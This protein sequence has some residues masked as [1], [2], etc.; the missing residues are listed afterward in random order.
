M[1]APQ[2]PNERWSLDFVA[3]Q[4]I[5]GRRMRILVVVDD[6]SRAGGL[7]L[8]PTLDLGLAG[9]PRTQSPD[10]P[11]IALITLPQ[12]SQCPRDYIFDDRINELS[13]P[14]ANGIGTSQWA[15]KTEI[16]CGL[17]LIKG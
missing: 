15:Q 6:C 4:F 1:L 10:N 12:S 8:I 5:D 13:H 17:R 3:D 7:A 14:G 16:P 11:S 9:R 2:L